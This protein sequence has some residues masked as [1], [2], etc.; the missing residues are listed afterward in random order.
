MH[1]PRAIL[2][3]FAVLVAALLAAG[4][5]GELTKSEYQS[6]VSSVGSGVQDDM[7]AFTNAEKPTKGD[8]EKA[9]G[10]LH[11]AADELDDIDPPSEVAKLHDQLVDVLDDTADLFGEMAPLLGKAS[12]DPSKMDKADLAKMSSVTSEFSKIQGRMEKVQEG[13]A[14]KGY[15]KLGI[16]G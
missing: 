1:R 6:K 15:T 9:E 14:D 5:G 4:C 10:A 16:E 11:S 7:E 3:L 2:A 12:S 8:L 13:Y